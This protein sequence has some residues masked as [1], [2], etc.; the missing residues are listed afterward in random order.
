[1]RG[2]PSRPIPSPRREYRDISRS[3]PRSRNMSLMRPYPDISPHHDMRSA[4]ATRDRSPLTFGTSSGGRPK[5]VDYGHRSGKS[6][7]YKSRH[8]PPKNFQASGHLVLS[9]FSLHRVFAS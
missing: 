9:S 3:P 6:V 2:Y 8:L 1:M 4:R 7:D 5:V